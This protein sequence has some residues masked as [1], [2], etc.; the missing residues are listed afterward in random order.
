MKNKKTDVLTIVVLISLDIL[1]LMSLRITALEIGERFGRIHI[2]LEVSFYVL[3][4]VV[5]LG[6]IVYPIVRVFLS[7][8]FSLKDLHGADGKARQNWCRKLV[9]N[10][11]ENV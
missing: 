3:I 5:C 2:S 1:I 6:G 10:L 11:I 7:P 8:I 4:A 9:D